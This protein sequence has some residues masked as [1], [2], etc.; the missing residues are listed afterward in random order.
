MFGTAKRWIDILLKN[1]LFLVGGAIL[2]LTWANWD[3]AN[4]THSYQNFV[5]FDF[6]SVFSAGEHAGN[7]HA[8]AHETDDHA[9]EDHGHTTGHATDH[10]VALHSADHGSRDDG[11]ASS[12]DEQHAAAVTDLAEH[13]GE[14]DNHA[15]G[16]GYLTVH[17]L[18]NDVLMALFFALA[19]KEVW[20]AFL[21]GG[22]LSNVRKAATPLLATLGGIVGPALVYLAGAA[23]VGQMST[24]GSGWAIPCATDIAFGYLVARL[25]FGQGHPAISFLLLLAIADDAAGLVILALFYPS[26]EVAPVWL[27]G[28]AAAV[29]CGIGMKKSGVKNFWWY[30]AIP[31][32]VSWFSFFKAGIHPALGLVPIIPT[33]PH[34]GEDQGL[35]AN[36]ERHQTDTLNQFEHWFKNPVEVILG[37]FALVNAGVVF[38]S[39]GAGTILVLGGLLV[40]KPVGI[41]LCSVLAVRGMKLELPE[42]MSMKHVVVVGFI[43]SLGFTVALFVSTAAFPVPGPIQDAAKMGALASFL[44]PIVAVGVCLLLGLRP[45]FLGQPSRTGKG[46]PFTGAPA[47]N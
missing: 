42:G 18:V 3:H 34:S 21:P 20:E 28:A 2:A 45:A 32:V 37:L 14:H 33:L 17:F 36:E 27:L 38:S 6:G 30:L 4:Q 26:A 41:A 43:A 25:I 44:T 16:H 40:G 5:H 19:A 12:H 47:S 8:G 22:S 24:L 9:M 39:V 46:A 23:A 10:V 31:G 7:E 1:S 15:G 13:S 29:A 11:H 35:F